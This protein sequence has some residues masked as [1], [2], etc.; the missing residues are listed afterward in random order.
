[1]I[2]SFKHKGLAKFFESGSTAGIQAA[3]AKRLRLIL[4]R[5]NAAT[6]AEDM[7]LPGL[8]LHKLSGNRTDVWSVTV[9]GNWR[10]TFRFEDGDAEIVNYEDYH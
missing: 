2:R 4:G 8:R 1:M 5:L 3:H 6:G 7:D 10:V 9:S